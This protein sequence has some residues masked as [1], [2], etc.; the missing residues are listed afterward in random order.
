MARCRPASWAKAPHRRTPPRPPTNTESHVRLR[1]VGPR[2]PHRLAAVVEHPAVE[3]S[4]IAAD[5]GIV[6]ESHRYCGTSLTFVAFKGSFGSKRINN[7]TPPA[8]IVVPTQRDIDA[9]V[10]LPFAQIDRIA[11]MFKSSMYSKS[12]LPLL[13]LYMISLITTGPIRGPLF[14]APKVRETIG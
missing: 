11:V 13:A 4:G 3:H 7:S 2:Q 8:G 5:E 12:S 1:H 9:A 14:A 10:D 6:G